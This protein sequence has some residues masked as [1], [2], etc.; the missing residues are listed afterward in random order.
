MLNA[1]VSVP[2][3][4]ETYR[5][6]ERSRTDEQKERIAQE[7]KKLEAQYVSI[8]ANE[9]VQETETPARRLERFRSRLLVLQL[10]EV[11][12]QLTGER[13]DNKARTSKKRKVYLYFDLVRAKC[14]DAGYP[15]GGV[16][17]KQPW[18]AEQLD[19]TVRTVNRLQ[20]KARRFVRK[21]GGGNHSDF[22]SISLPTEGEALA[23]L[24]EAYEAQAA[25][26]PEDHDWPDLF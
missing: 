13:R 21:R 18:I 7:I 23:R 6:V 11:R 17:I 9:L 14:K 2:N 15:E 10:Q 24:I 1:A 22:Y 20:S 3:A 26:S 16:K 12:Y 4:V 8:E 19:C 25:L 5:E